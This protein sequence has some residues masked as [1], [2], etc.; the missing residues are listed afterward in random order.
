MTTERRWWKC[1]ETGRLL[2]ERPEPGFEWVWVDVHQPDEITLRKLAGEFDLDEMAIE[3]ALDTDL[4]P[5]QED[6]GD[7]FSVALRVITAT[8]QSAETTPVLAFVGVRFLVTIHHTS[9]VG[10]EF[11]IHTAQTHLPSTEGG[12]DRMLARLADVGSRRFEPI[13]HEID[14]LLLE[15][16]KLALDGEPGSMRLL[17]PVRHQIN[18]LRSVIRPQR[19][20]LQALVYA[21]S[22]LIGERA[23]RRLT[24]VLERHARIEESLDVDRA[25][26]S[27]VIDLYRGTVAEQTNEIMKVLTVFSAVLLPM[28]LIAGIYGMNF[29]NMPELDYRFGY[30]VIIGLMAAVG[31]VLWRLFVRRG[32]VGRPVVPDLAASASLRLAAAATRPA[33]TVGSVITANLRSPRR[34]R[35]SR[36]G[37]PHRLP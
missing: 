8:E 22:P 33:R 23:R 27:S 14:G 11:L 20:V 4:F 5:S 9:L 31:L 37:K 30:P 21:D 29:A 16:E 7:F 25:A 15:S 12:P 17:Q 26:A 13:L 28:T 19:S 6:F 36:L 18:D 10:L 2:A 3:D 1:A 32:F 34:Q 35:S 24:D